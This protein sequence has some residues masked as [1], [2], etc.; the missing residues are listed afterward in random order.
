MLAGESKQ[1][2]SKRVIVD[3][4]RREIEREGGKHGRE[5]LL[6]GGFGGGMPP[7]R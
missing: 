7:K 3:N 2:S 1:M 4:E 5:A 6:V